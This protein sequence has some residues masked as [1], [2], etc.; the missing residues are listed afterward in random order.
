[1]RD[2]LR[3]GNDAD[4]V[5]GPDLGGKAA[6]DAEHSA[7]DDGGEGEEIEDLT[8]GFPDGGVAVLLL[9]LLIETIH[10]CDLA[11]FVVAADE[12]DLVGVSVRG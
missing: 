12:G 11:R 1:M 2:F 7:V 4:L 6:M 10:L 5:E 8:A 9:A 3:T